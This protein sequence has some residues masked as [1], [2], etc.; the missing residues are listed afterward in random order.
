MMRTIELKPE[1]ARNTN[2]GTKT[3]LK[4]V[5]ITG[6]PCPWVFPFLGPPETIP[7]V[8]VARN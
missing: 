4:K 1:E 6:I 8:P 7:V 2:G 3:P 5:C